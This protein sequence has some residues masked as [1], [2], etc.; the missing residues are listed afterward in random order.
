VDKAI[1]AAQ[2]SIQLNDKSGDAHSLLADLYGRKFHW[3]TPCSQARSSAPR[4]TRKMPR[5]WR[6]MTKILASGQPWPSILD[7]PEDVWRRRPQGHRE[8]SEVFGL[9]YLAG[10]NLG[11]AG[12]GLSKQGDTSKSTGSGTT[13]LSLNRGSRFALTTAA[14][15]EKLGEELG[16]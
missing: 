15:L 12:Q 6:S 1:D 9:R 7:D 13:R 4:S 11:M 5:L 2:H 16:L 14:S 10:R 3:A 8:L